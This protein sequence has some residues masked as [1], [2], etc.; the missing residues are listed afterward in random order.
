MRNAEEAIFDQLPAGRT[1]GCKIGCDAAQVAL[2]RAASPHP[3][4]LSADTRLAAARATV[5]NVE[6]QFDRLASHIAKSCG[7]H[8]SSVSG[9]TRTSSRRGATSGRAPHARTGR[10]KMTRT[11][12]I[13]AARSACRGRPRSR[14]ENAPEA[15]HHP[16]GNGACACRILVDV[17]VI[18]KLLTDFAVFSVIGLRSLLADDGLQQFLHSAP[19]GTSHAASRSVSRT[20]RQPAPDHDRR[21]VG[22]AGNHGRMIARR[23]AQP[24]DPCRAV[25]VDMA[26]ASRRGSLKQRRESLKHFLRHPAHPARPACPARPRCT[27]ALASHPACRPRPRRGLQPGGARRPARLGLDRRRRRGR[28]APQGALG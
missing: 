25:R 19:C 24:G 8:A 22:V 23:N 26:M 12:A 13:G 3:P 10:L 20:D 14:L 4:A 1:P 17:G 11:L 15:A 6:F 27:W 28:I 9:W 7:P 5:G 21:G 16:F 18:A 2:R